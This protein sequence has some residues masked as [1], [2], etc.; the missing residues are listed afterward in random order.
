M[1]NWINPVYDRKQSDVDYA[2][3]RIEYFKTNGGVTDGVDLKGCFNYSDMNRIENNIQYLHDRLNK[4]Y[5]FS[6]MDIVHGWNMNSVP[7][8]NEDMVR[9]INNVT[10]LQSAYYEPM[11]SV[12]QPDNLLRFNRVNNLEKNM[13]YIKEM[14]DDMENSFRECGNYECGEG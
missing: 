7:R 1:A 4:L 6:K 8:K 11:L 14:I 9:V 13:L 2:K 12:A 3:E 5:Y 10:L